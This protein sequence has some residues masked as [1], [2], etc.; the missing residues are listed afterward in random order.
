M[1]SLHGKDDNRPISLRTTNTRMVEDILCI[2]VPYTGNMVRLAII[3][4][5]LKRLSTLETGLLNI[6]IFKEVL[7]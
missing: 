3:L 7:L 6:F 1:E 2:V 4:L 5:M